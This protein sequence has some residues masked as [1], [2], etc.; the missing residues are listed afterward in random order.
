[1]TLSG[2]PQADDPIATHKIVSGGGTDNPY[3]FST[4]SASKL[5]GEQRLWD[6]I[7]SEQTVRKKGWVSVLTYSI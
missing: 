3:L 5:P 6:F 4:E 2:F 7:D 1:M